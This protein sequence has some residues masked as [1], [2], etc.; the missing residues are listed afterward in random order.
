MARS[1]PSGSSRARPRLLILRAE[2][3]HEEAGRPVDVRQREEELWASRVPVLGPPRAEG[4]PRKPDRVAAALV[5]GPAHGADG[6]R[7]RASGPDALHG[8]TQKV[9]LEVGKRLG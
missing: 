6:V 1:P 2:P 8:R 5:F 4:A 7:D 9:Q 3:G